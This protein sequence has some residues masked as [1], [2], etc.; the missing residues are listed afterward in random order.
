MF[1]KFF[2]RRREKKRQK[3]FESGWCWAAREFFLENRKV[4]E[5]E[6]YLYHAR[7][8]NMYTEFDRGAEHFI[9][10]LDLVPE[11]FASLW[12]Q[13]KKNTSR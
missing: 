6:G 1:K 5:I 12:L 8:A 11:D 2:E 10:Q 7:L 9:R 3:D 13:N 4:V